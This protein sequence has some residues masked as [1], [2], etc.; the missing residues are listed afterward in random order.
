MTTAGPSRFQ[1]NDLPTYKETTSSRLKFLYSDFSRQKQSNPASFTSNIEWWRRTLEAIVLNGYQS[2][3][4]T[5]PANPDRLVFHAVGP[6]VIEQFRVEGVGKPL[7]LATVIV[8]KAELCHLKTFFPLSQFRT[9]KQS[10]YDP[11]WLP[12]RIASFVIGKPLWW[13]LQQLSIVSSEDGAGSESD[14]QRWRKVKGDYVVVSLMEQAAEAVLHKQEAKAGLSLA[15]S[16]YGFDG[17]KR[18][19]GTCAFGGL[20]LSNMDIKVLVK[21][22]ERDRQA[23]VVQRGVIK[24]VAYS[25]SAEITPVDIGVLELK[26]AVE[27]LETGIDRLQ[28]QI[29]ERAVRISAALQQKRRE[30]AL[31]HLRAKKQFE[32]LLKKRLNALDTLQ[33]T[34]TRV[35]ASAGDIQILKS[36]E[37]SSA[38][39]RAILADPSLQRDKIDETMEAMASANAEAKEIDDAIRSGAEIAQAEIGADDSEL[40]EELA[41]LVKEMELEKS[42]AE[43]AAARKDTEAKLSVAGLVTPVGTHAM[44]GT[45]ANRT[46]V[47]LSEN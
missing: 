25:P 27:S 18:E 40:D 33:A 20:E 45:P 37:S 7:G 12:Y 17:F 8:R 4:P 44:E 46:K 9:S 22:L 19:F 32:D 28:G 3:S 2:Q 47:L 6:Q 15:D 42:S 13:T 26:S 41:V 39:L 5:H 35:E 16:L 31:S 29:D 21:F 10:I 23:V 30:M 38:T 34:L 43:V 14:A 24:F 1:L 11:G 36:Y